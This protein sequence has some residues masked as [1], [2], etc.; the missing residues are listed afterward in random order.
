MSNNEPIILWG[1]SISPYVRKVLLA[2]VEKDLVYEQ[3]ETLPKSLL[4][5]TSKIVPEDFDSASPLG[6]IPA[7]QIGNFT[8]A[9]SAVITAYLDRRFTSGNRL[10]PLNPESYARTLWF[11]RYS[12]TTLT[13]VIY[14]KLFL[15]CVVKP[16]VLNQESD[17]SLVER[18]KSIELPIILDYLNNSINSEWIA[19]DEFTSADIAIATQLLAL[20]LTGFDFEKSRWNNLYRYF[21]KVISRPSFKK[22]NIV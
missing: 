17:K 21:E 3:R 1:V 6:K 8:I 14:K 11:E 16:A 22:I 20:N 2:L 10:Y 4:Q 5:A 7:I 18:T 15:E 12:D 13:D 9:D 19:G